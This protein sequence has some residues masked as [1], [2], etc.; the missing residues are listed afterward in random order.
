MRSRLRA[1][2]GPCRRRQHRYDKLRI[3]RA[4]VT[5]KR[6]NYVQGQIAE[7]QGKD[8]TY[9]I[10]RR[11]GNS[12]TS[13]LTRSG[14]GQA[15]VYNT[16]GD[17][18]LAHRAEGPFSP[19]RTRQRYF[20]TAKSYQRSR[21]RLM[22]EPLIRGKFNARYQTWEHLEDAPAIHRYDDAIPTFS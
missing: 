12:Y 17:G 4:V 1:Q 9:R 15:H 14:F 8:R 2:R 18:H 22:D 21:S 19:V 5:K 16:A 13:K 7:V 3:N 20:E 6:P 11:L 10:P